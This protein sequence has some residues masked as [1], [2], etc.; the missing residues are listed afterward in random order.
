[1][2]LSREDMVTIM[3]MWL[4]TLALMLFLALFVGRGLDARLNALD[5]ACGVEQVEEGL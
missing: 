1:M 3:I 4:S 5:A 2:S